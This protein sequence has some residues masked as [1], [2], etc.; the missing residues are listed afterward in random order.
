[1][2]DFMNGFLVLIRHTLDDLPVGLFRTE[3]EATTFALTCDI[4]VETKR[5]AKLMS[6]DATTP[7]CVAIVS[8]VDETPTA[9]DIVRDCEE[10]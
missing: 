3:K 8:F 4:D 1:M 2:G 5:T 7:I 6:L 10:N 9:C